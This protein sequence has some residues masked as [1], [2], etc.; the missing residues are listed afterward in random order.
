MYTFQALFLKG[1]TVFLCF[2]TINV[3]FDIKLFVLF[4]IT[5]VIVF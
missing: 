2:S 4:D 1:K 5:A 3:F